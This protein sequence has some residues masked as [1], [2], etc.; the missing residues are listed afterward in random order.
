MTGDRYS[1]RGHIFLREVVLLCMGE[2]KYYDREVG[3]GRGYNYDMTDYSKNND[4][5]WG[6]YSMGVTLL[7]YIAW[8][9]ISFSQ[10]KKK[11]TFSV[12]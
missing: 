7:Y 3:G 4:R 6:R 11:T 10:K 2:S 1:M 9:L 12:D 8:R 5:E